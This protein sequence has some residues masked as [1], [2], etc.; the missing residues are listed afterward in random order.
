MHTVNSLRTLGLSGH[1]MVDIVGH[2]NTAEMLLNSYYLQL[3]HVLSMKRASSQACEDAL[4]S[5]LPAVT[6]YFQAHY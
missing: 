6:S 4:S 3:K 2:G 5:E 1:Q